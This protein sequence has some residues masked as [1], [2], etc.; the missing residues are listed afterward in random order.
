MV[1]CA[2]KR[3]S[4]QHWSWICDVPIPVAFA[5]SVFE[6]QMFAECAT[7]VGFSDTFKSEISST[8][9]FEI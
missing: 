7:I 9:K 8:N 2:A 5:K 6:E 1:D 4:D 3:G